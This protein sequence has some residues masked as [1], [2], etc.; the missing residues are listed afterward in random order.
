MCVF[1]FF[2]KQ[3]TAYEMRI[4][5]WSSDVCSSDLDMA[6]VAG[7]EPRPLV[8]LRRVGDED[9]LRLGLVAPIAVHDE[10]TAHADFAVVGDPHFG[11]HQRR[12][13][14]IH[15][16]PC[17]GAVAAYD[18]PRLGMAIALQQGQARSEAHTTDLQ[19]TT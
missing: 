3:K 19:S 5:D 7:M 16:E 15:L 1:F 6:D 12:P 14:R 18:R 13:D 11:V 2:F 4:S 9:A 17:R 8:G 10:L